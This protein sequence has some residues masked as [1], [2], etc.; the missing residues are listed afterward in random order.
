MNKKQQGKKRLWFVI[1][2]LIIV[3][4]VGLNLLFKDV[5]WQVDV[6]EEQ[7]FTLDE[8]THQIIDAL[9]GD[10][11]IK[12]FSS[13]NVPQNLIE[14]KQQIEDLLGEYASASERVE[15]EI[16]YPIEDTSAKRQADDFGIPEVNYNIV[17]QE[18]IEV[19]KGYS[20]IVVLY[21]DENTALPV[22][23][24]SYDLEYSITA[25]IKKM[26][27]ESQNTISFF[28]EHIG[29]PFTELQASLTQQYN[30]DGVGT[31]E[32]WELGKG[33]VLG[34]VAAVEPLTEDELFAIDQF[35]M[36]GGKL[37]A[38][39]GSVNV[40]GSDFSWS[41]NNTGIEQLLAHY[42]IGIEKK[43][44]ADFSSHDR[45]TFN[46]GNS[47]VTKEYPMWVVA[48]QGI[49]GNHPIT[50][51]VR[52]FLIPWANPITIEARDGFSVDTLVTTTPDSYAFS[53]EELP[54]IRPDN[55]YTPSQPSL[56]E[57]AVA[58]IG[59]GKIDSYYNGK[60]IPDAEKP[61]LSEVEDGSVLAVSS[62]WIINDNLL[63]RLP[64][65]S[66]LAL[67]AIDFLVEKGSLSDLRDAG[68]STRPLE[69][70]DADEKLDFKVKLVATLI[71]TVCVFGLLILAKRKYH[72]KKAL[73]NLKGA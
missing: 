45:M 19:L 27:I 15:L 62:P 8:K 22:I 30:V 42:G 72:E 33:D 54:N 5:K 28:K 25:A 69:N 35:V 17:E 58:V 52:S 55:I 21:E 48:S 64:S 18:N 9:E 16:L 34:V 13:K 51:G 31:D 56:K 7:R 2:G 73:K 26:S 37:F 10:V 53:E 68:L 70:L 1:G 59:S 6:T 57:Y 49:Q 41:E 47:N 3:L 60:E 12:Y 23:R 11:T 29:I 50:S 39:Q 43:L 71:I 38:F 65:N 44:I 20:G 66:T 40:N 32:I 67:S 24:S 14:N 4:A 36:R 46:D 61:F 63:S